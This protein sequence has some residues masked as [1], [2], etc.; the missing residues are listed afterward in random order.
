MLLSN[1]ALL[2]VLWERHPG[3]PNL[4][5]AYVDGPRELA[6]HGYVCKPL[7]GREGAGVEV[8]P[9][10]RPAPVVADP[11]CFQAFVPL[12]SFDGH[13]PV[14]GAWVVDGEPAGLG[15]R[16]TPGLITNGSATFVPHL[17]PST[18]KSP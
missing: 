2:A 18:T 14:L 11:S 1:K 5:P 16:E 6:R 7:L 8:V 4:V 9:P 15:I 3:H 17:I 10:G 12:P 13:R